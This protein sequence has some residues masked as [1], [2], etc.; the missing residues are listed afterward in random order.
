MTRRC[1]A[2][3]V[4]IYVDAILNH[5]SADHAFEVIGTGGSRADPCTR[6][7]SAVPYSRVDFHPKC[8][9]KNYSNPVEVRN[10][11]LV[12]LHDLDQRSEHVRDKLV[13]F[14]NRAIADGVAGFRY[15]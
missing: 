10:C 14:M 12:G 9:L 3:G 1:N 11:E 7:F 15:C 4:R 2:V 8:E 13:E 5:M 6:N